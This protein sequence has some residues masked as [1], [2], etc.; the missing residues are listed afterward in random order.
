LSGGRQT[1][2]NPFSW[3]IGGDDI[4]LLEKQKERKKEKKK[5]RKEE[6][7]K[8]IEKKDQKQISVGGEKI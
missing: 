3:L 7:R 8:K 1:K 6:K 5:G 2:G 4:E